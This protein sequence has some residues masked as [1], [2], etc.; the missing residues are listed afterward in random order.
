MKILNP[1]FRSHFQKNIILC[2]QCGSNIF[3]EC[4]RKTKKVDDEKTRIFN[5]Q[6]RNCNGIFCQ[7]CGINFKNIEAYNDHTSEFATSKTLEN[8]NV[9]VNQIFKVFVIINFNWNQM[10]KLKMISKKLLWKKEIGGV[11]GT[12]WVEVKSQT[13]KE[14][15]LLSNKMCQHSRMVNVRFVHRRTATIVLVESCVRF[16]TI[17]WFLPFSRKFFSR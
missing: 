1:K 13:T 15:N 6:H 17:R 5:E 10:K 16:V 3:I 11:K 8:V 12:R 7:N 14:V 9:F 2:S 4:N